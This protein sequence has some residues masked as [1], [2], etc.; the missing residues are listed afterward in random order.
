MRQRN[1]IDNG[2]SR[3]KYCD[4]RADKM[5]FVASGLFIA[6]MLVGAAFGLYPVVLLATVQVGFAK[7]YFLVGTSAGHHTIV[8][9]FGVGSGSH[10]SKGAS[11]HRH[12]SV[13][14]F[15]SAR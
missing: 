13:G 5:A 12:C 2:S 8:G 15:G 3:V 10:A 7:S 1:C 11:S 14:R 9:S 6:G 4:K